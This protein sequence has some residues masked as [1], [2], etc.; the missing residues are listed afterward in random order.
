MVEKNKVIVVGGGAAGIMSAITAARCGA[1]VTILEKNPR[2]GKKI[3]WHPV[4]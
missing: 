2:I 3:L 1:E 4:P